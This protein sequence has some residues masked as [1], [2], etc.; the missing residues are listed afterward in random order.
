MVFRDFLVEKLCKDH[1]LVGD[2]RVSNGGAGFVFRFS[3]SQ[4]SSEC[5][6]LCV[7]KNGKEDSIFDLLG[8]QSRD[9]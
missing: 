3:Q 2:G 7:G 4:L 8:I 1:N 6:D 9:R 5:G